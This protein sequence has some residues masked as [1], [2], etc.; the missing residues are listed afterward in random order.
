MSI[1]KVTHLSFFDNYIKKNTKK[2]ALGK[3]AIGKKKLK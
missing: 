2:K 3:K 1:N